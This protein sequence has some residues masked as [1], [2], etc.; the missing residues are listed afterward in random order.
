MGDA[1][2]VNGSKA[3]TFNPVIPLVP[4]H[5]AEPQV[6]GLQT[7]ADAGLAEISFRCLAVPQVASRPYPATPAPTP[8]PTARV[9][10][11]PA[12]GPSTS[13]RA[14]TSPAN[15]RPRW[16]VTTTSARRRTVL[17]PE[18]ML[19]RSGPGAMHHGKLFEFRIRIRMFFMFITHRC[20][21][22]TDGISV[23]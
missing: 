13:P 8:P 6:I 19:L 3:L 16:S 23:Q 21:D 10:A 18:V 22:T 9:T 1:G 15:P 14:A 11:P 20:N 17:T 12:A 7:Y 5:A 4:P 2:E